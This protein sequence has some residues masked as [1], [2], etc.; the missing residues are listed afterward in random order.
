[1]AIAGVDTQGGNTLAAL[2]NAQQTNRT[3][4]TRSQQAQEARFGTTETTEAED[5]QARFGA[6]TGADQQQG[7]TAPGN[8]LASNSLSAL[9]QAT[10]EQDQNAAATATETEEQDEEANA[11][12]ST[13]SLLPGAT[14]N[15]GS[16]FSDA[17]GVSLLV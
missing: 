3:D 13:N 5:R 6:E 14:D 17:R 11:G 10:Q 16:G 9:I 8:S 7:F 12:N 1:M 2:R 15:N 4:E